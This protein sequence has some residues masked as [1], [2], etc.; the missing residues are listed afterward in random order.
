PTDLD[1]NITATVNCLSGGEAVVS[2]GSTLSSAGPFFFSIYQGPISVYPNPPGSWIPEDSPGSESATF[3]GLTPGVSY[4]FIVYDASTNC[5][6]YE[7]ATTPIPTNST[8]TVTAVSADNITCTGSADGTVSFTVNSSYGVATGITYEIFASL[9]LASTGV[10]G[11]GSVPASGSF[12]V[13]DLGPLP[14]GNYF[15]QITETSGPNSGCGIVTAP[16]N[17]TESEFL[18]NLSVSVDQNANC[19]PNS[20]VISAVGHDGTAPYQYQ[21]TTSATAPTETDPAWASASVFNMDAGDY[22]V[23]VMDAYNCIVSSPITLP[24]DPAPVISAT[25]TDQ[26]TTEEGAYQID[27]A[28]TATGMPPYSFSINGGAF[29]T[30]TAPFSISNLYSG[31]H[32][33]EVQDA[34]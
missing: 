12:T 30:Q 17:I 16:F 6:Y 18:L 1:I 33:I 5:S 28:L 14:F 23:H 10:T 21:I 4:T 19:N 22:Y 27:V 29:Q 2:I 3:T 34:N 11:S 31:T 20:G 24:M 9:S 13:T 26:C 25:L 32:T 15:V 8:L 7:P